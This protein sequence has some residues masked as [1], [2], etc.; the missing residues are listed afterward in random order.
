MNIKGKFNFSCIFCGKQFPSYVY[1]FASNEV[2]S[3]VLPVVPIACYIRDLIVHITLR[4]VTHE[5][6]LTTDKLDE[7]THTVQFV[8]C[9]VMDA[10]ANLTVKTHE[11]P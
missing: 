6:V 9:R 1:V 7:K 11:T 10:F 8:E 5:N 3:N 4:T 2:G